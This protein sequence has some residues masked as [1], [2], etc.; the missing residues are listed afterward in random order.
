MASEAGSLPGFHLR[1]ATASERVARDRLTCESWG[2]SLTRDQY[3]DRERVLRQTAHG[4]HAMHTW[5][6]KVSN[7]VVMAS[8]ETFRIPLSPGGAVEV[9]ASV[10]VDKPLRGAG[11][12]RRMLAALVAHRREAGLDGLVLFSEVGAALYESVGFRLL[13]SPTRVVPATA[14]AHDPAVTLLGPDALPDLLERR[15]RLR[16]DTVDVRLTPELFEWHAA[17]ARFY[18]ETSGRKLPATIG[19]RCGDAQVMWVTDVKATTLRLLDASGPPGT[20]LTPLLNAA[21]H[22][23]HQHRLRRA[24]LWDDTHSLALAGPAAVERDDDLPMGQSFTPRG[25]LF[26]GPL[27]RAAWA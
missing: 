11:L 22:E 18:A 1:E 8:C 2:G 17:R 5:V 14:G 20:D 6:L 25:E 3:L 23:A 19:A 15:E 9:I 27:G 12:A 7:G 10:Y 26:L 13:P 24:V 16:R 4:T 21:A